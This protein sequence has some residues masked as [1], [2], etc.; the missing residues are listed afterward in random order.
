MARVWVILI[1]ILL[2]VT[3]WMSGGR[4][5]QAV[6]ISTLG[7]LLSIFLLW[8]QHQSHRT[9]SILLQ[10]ATAVWLGWGALSIIWSVSRYDSELWLLYALLGVLVFAA[11]ASLDLAAKAQLL[12]GYVWLATLMAVVGF[13]IY[14]TGDYNRL[15][16]SFYWANPAAAWLLPAALLASWGWL[17]R[18]D[19]A[20]WR[21]ALQAVQVLILGTAVWLTDSRGALLATLIVLIGATAM[22]RRLRQRALPAVG[23]ILISFGLATGAA[24]L[25]SHVKHQTTVAPG[26]RFAQAAEGESTSGSDRLNYLR[27]A[28]SIWQHHPL[29]GTGAGTYGIEHPQY[30]RRVISASSDAHNIV[31]QTLA[32]QGLPGMLW[33]LYL[34]VILAWGVARGVRRE[35]AVGIAAAGAVIVALH[36]GVDID[37]RYPALIALLA[38]LAGVAYQPWQ[39]MRVVPVRRMAIPVLLVVTLVLAASSYESNFWATRGQQ[40]DSQSLF[41]NAAQAYARAHTTPVYDPTNWTAE[42]IDYYT[43]ASFTGGSKTYNADAERAARGAIQHD[44]SDSQ[45]YQLLG[46]IQALEGNLP[47]AEASLSQALRLD[48]WNHP[49]YYSDLAGLQLKANHTVAAQKTVSAGLALYPDSVIANRNADTTVKPAVAELLSLQAADRLSHDDTKGAAADIKRALKLDPSETDA[50]QL[51][52]HGLSS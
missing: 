42:G 44:G 20:S 19:K 39:V 8:R 12:A 16:T 13:Y 31:L 29:L 6:L 25:W 3:P 30:Q 28:V 48:P 27:S 1:G 35:P 23:V 38:M 41:T 40:A 11:T 10:A 52:A 24:A 37:D 32:E 26:S 34:A 47:A 49:D 2:A 33:L 50:L 21:G 22:S 14:A 36:F 7:L 46:R 18:P 15:T 17:N 45:N 51:Q 43:L 4:D 5:P 9:A